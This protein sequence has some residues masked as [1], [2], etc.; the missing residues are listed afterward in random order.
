MGHSSGRGLSPED[1]HEITATP[2]PGKRERA[3][4]GEVRA[5][6]QAPP[7][8]GNVRQEH[9]LVPELVRV[10]R[11]AQLVDRDRLLDAFDTVLR[12]TATA[13][14]LRPCHLKQP[15][16]R[17]LVARRL[18]DV[19][20]AAGPK[21]A[22]HLG[23]TPVEL[24]KVVQEPLDRHAV[25]LAVAKAQRADV[26]PLQAGLDGGRRE[27]LARAPEHLGRVVDADDLEAPP[28]KREADDARAAA[29]VERTTAGA[30]LRYPVEERPQEPLVID[31]ELAGDLLVVGGRS[32]PVELDVP[33]GELV[34]RPTRRVR[35][36]RRRPRPWALR[37]GP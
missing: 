9:E 14:Q 18:G 30:R 27:L 8:R 11:S 17:R 15:P 25:E 28:G 24:L 13:R 23:N 6:R 36:A 31:R 4:D 37:A 29:E 35:V 32:R 34:A 21:Y 26:A 2:P 7:Q 1:E 3:R 10:E 5:V 12:V 16:K 33:P 20:E 22:N 19:E